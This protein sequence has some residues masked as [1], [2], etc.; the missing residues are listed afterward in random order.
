MLLFTAQVELQHDLL[1][2]SV[3]QLLLLIRKR[4]AADQGWIVDVIIV[5]LYG[6]FGAQTKLR[7][8]SLC[9][10]L[11]DLKNKISTETK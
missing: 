6:L 9:M 1:L 4:Q 11:W 8:E 5:L 10:Y 7:S 2:F 3:L